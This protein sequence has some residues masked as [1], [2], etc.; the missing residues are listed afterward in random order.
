MVQFECH[1]EPASFAQRG[2]W[3]S[4]AKGRGFCDQQ[5][6][7]WLA[8]LFKLTHYPENRSLF[9]YPIN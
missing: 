9:S 3:A 5:T 2:I 8:T 4:R 1:P 7:V 6:R